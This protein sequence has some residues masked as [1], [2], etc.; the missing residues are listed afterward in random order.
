MLTLIL[1]VTKFEFDKDWARMIA[2]KMI[3]MNIEFLAKCINN[4]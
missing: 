2:C 3:T 4:L 1:T